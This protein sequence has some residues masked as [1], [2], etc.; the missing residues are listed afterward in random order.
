MQLKNKKNLQKSAK[1][2]E[3]PVKAWEELGKILKNKKENIRKLLK[4]LREKFVWKNG[5]REIAS[6]RHKKK[7]KII[8]STNFLGMRWNMRNI[9]I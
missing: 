9:L 8:E 5:E 1:A 3:K 6:W 4:R 7:S 2:K